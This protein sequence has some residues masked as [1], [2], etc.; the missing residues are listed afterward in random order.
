M[1]LLSIEVFVSFCQHVSLFRHAPHKPLVL[2]SVSS[3]KIK[4]TRNRPQ[5]GF[6]C[7]VFPS[8]TQTVFMWAISEQTEQ[9]RCLRETSVLL[10]ASKPLALL[11]QTLT[12]FSNSGADAFDSLTTLSSKES[13]VCESFGLN[14][15]CCICLIH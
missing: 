4:Q 3:G 11:V 10:T 2:A 15:F 5:S 9:E 12:R 14:G 1:N 6:L 8:E 13:L 7:F